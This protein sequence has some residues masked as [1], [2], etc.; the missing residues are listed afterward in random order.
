[1]AARVSGVWHTGATRCGFST[2][3]RSLKL[4]EVEFTFV[5]RTVALSLVLMF[6]GNP[7]FADYD[8]NAGRVVVTTSDGSVHIYSDTGGKINTFVGERYCLGKMARR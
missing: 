4:K 8:E 6:S 5:L 7:V 3:Q 2:W 1:M